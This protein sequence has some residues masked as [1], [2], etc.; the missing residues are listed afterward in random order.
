MSTTLPPD[1]G[2]MPA[3][4]GSGAEVAPVPV[5]A[6]HL[7][8]AVCVRAGC[9][10]SPAGACI[11][12]LLAAIWEYP[13]LP[14]RLTADVDVTRAHYFDAYAGRDGQPLPEAFNARRD[15]YVGRYKDMETLRVLGLLPDA[16]VPAYW[17]YSFLF[18]RQ[19][20]LDGIC[21]TDS[22]S[23]AAWPECPHARAG[24]YERIA[25]A[26]E[27]VSLQQQTAQGEALAG[28]G[29]WAMIRPRT[30]E[31]MARA[32]AASAEFILH[33]ATRLFIR[34]N[35]ALC[36]L[37]TRHQ[38]TPLAEDNLV[39][40]RRR[41][42][43]EPDI[44]VTLTEGC[45]MVCDPCNIYHPG[46]HL[47]YGTHIKNTLRDLMVLERL[48]LPPGATLPARELY[49]RIYARIGTLQEICGW[50]DGSNT[51]MCWAPCGGYQGNALEE[52]RA[53]GWCVR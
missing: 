17:A 10:T 28:R 40:L 4:A 1:P 47:C 13:Y 45:C 18:A 36:I 31:E 3:H 35:H 41:M 14:L 49:A 25:G 7:L 16:V 34:P 52:A 42:E 29:F 43:R 33:R 26:A 38:D 50:R 22:C 39:E 12:P 6:H 19:R 5:R 24:W 37:C 30:R 21:R 15:D 51:A 23:S 46:E 11:P 20:T 48:G 8:C 27:A 32:K 44:P 9:G 53:A 2:T